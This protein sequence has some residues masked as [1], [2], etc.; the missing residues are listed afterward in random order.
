MIFIVEL[1][2]FRW[3]TSKLAKLGLHHGEWNCQRRLLRRKFPDVIRPLDA[4]G[5]NSGSHAAHGPE[6]TLTDRKEATGSDDLESGSKHGHD[7]DHDHEHDNTAFAQIIGV[8][9]LE[10]GVVLHRC[11]SSPRSRKCD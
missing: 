8:G 11:V 10:F 1:V 5:H 9:I 7:H 2:A 4:H 3:G 6:G